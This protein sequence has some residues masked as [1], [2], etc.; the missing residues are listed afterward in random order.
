MA[1]D[2][3]IRE[4]SFVPSHV[5]RSLADLNVR[6][7]R[8][9]FHRLRSD[10][11]ALSEYLELDAVSLERIESELHE[12]IERDFPQELVALVTPAIS[13]RGVAAHRIEEETSK[14]FD[15]DVY[16]APRRRH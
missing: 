6:T 3:D 9:M 12:V 13:K 15:A 7:A 1:K 16:V 10:R 8:Q 5:A 2:I 14:Y 11:A 4:L